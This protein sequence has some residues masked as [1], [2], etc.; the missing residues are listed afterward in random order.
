MNN[1]P[2]CS[3]TTKRLLLSSPLTIPITDLAKLWQNPQVRQYLG[4]TLSEKEIQLKLSTLTNHWHQHGFGQWVV[5]I[6]SNRKTIGLC[7]LHHSEDGI[8]LSYMFF[9]EYW[10]QGLAYEA[11]EASL[12]H[13]FNSLNFS[14]IIAITQEMNQAS[15]KL[16][17]KL[18]MQHFGNIT[19]FNAIQRIYKLPISNLNR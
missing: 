15:C 18:G 1:L 11:A 12:N 13:G 3:L 14:E 8:E 17:E 10:G 16:L 2:L 7:G 4:G 6:K 5:Q 19:R 9:P